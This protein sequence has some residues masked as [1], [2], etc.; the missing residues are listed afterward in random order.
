M[1]ECMNSVAILPLAAAGWLG[2]MLE[3]ANWWVI[4][5]VALGLGFVIFVHELGHF[6][7]AKACGVKCEKFFLGFDVGARPNTAS[8]HC[9][10][11]AT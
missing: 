10:W 5:Q 11:A 4:L 7:V 2:W 9:R 3:P 1:G 8:A 6:L